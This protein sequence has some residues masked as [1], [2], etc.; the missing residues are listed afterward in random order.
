[1]EPSARSAWPDQLEAHF[2]DV[3][4]G[5]SRTR[6]ELNGDPGV[7]EIEALFLKHI[8]R[9]KRFIYAENQYFASRAVAEAI[10]ARLTEENPPEI[11]IVTPSSADGWVETLAM[12]PAR[13]QIV[14]AL[15]EIDVKDRFH[16]YVPYTGETPIY[17]HAKVL[18]VDDEVLR[19]GSANFNNRSMRLDSECD[20]FIDCA[21]PANG[22]CG[23]AI[24]GLRHSL[25]AE[26]CGV[27]EGQVGDLIEKAGSM[28]GMIAAL[29]ENRMR[30][31][32][33]F[34]PGEPTELEAEMANRQTLDPEDPAEMFRIGPPPRGR[35]LFRPGS[36]LARSMNRLKRK[37]R[38]A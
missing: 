34:V 6:A 5:I 12:D 30:K 10:S 13:A 19:V 4:I 25:L 24:R 28:A 7:H 38:R 17:V 31:L 1:M 22:H 32:R 27:P 15:Q 11:I 33:P 14:R 9:A 36:L 8:A 3:E 26:H 29:D 35:G 16:I 21:R 37:Q 18:I 23:A 2:T 20:V